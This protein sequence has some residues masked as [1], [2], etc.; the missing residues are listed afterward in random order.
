MEMFPGIRS[1]LFGQSYNLRERFP[2]GGVLGEQN[3]DKFFLVSLLALLI[4]AHGVA[5]SM[6]CDSIG[7]LEELKSLESFDIEE[8]TEVEELSDI[9]SWRSEHGGK[10]L[11]NIDSFGAAGDGESDDTEALQK[12]WGVAC[13]TPKSVL[14]IPQGRRYLVNATKFKRPCADKL[15]IQIDW[16]LVAPDEPKNWDPKLPRVWLDFSKLDKAVF[17]GSGVLMARENNFHP[18]KH[19]RKFI[20]EK[21]VYESGSWIRNYVPK[22]AAEIFWTMHPKFFVYFVFAL[23]LSFFCDL[24]SDLGVTTTNDPS[25]SPP[26]PGICSWVKSKKV[27]TQENFYHHKMSKHQSP[28]VSDSEEQVTLKDISKQLR[29]L[30]QWRIDTERKMDYA[31]QDRERK[32]T[33]IQDELRIMRD[34]Q[35]RMRGSR[36]GD[37]HH[38]TMMGTIL[39]HRRE[40]QEPPPPREV[41]INLPHFHGKDDVEAFLDWETKVEQLFACHQVSE[42]RKVPLATLSF[43]GYAMYWWTAIV[44]ERRR[45][46]NPPIRYWNDLITALRMRHIPSYY[47]R[48]LMDKL[49]R[50]QQN[51]MSVEQYRQKM[52]LYMIRAR[53]EETNEFTMARF[54]SGLNY[55]I[56]DK[57]ELL[58]Y[59]DLDSLVQM[60]IKVEQQNLRKSSH[61]RAQVQPFERRSFKEK[62]S[63]KPLAKIVEKPKQESSSHPRTS[64]IKCFKCLG[65]GHVAAQCPTKRN[66]ILRGK[67]IYS[68]ESDT[69]TSESEGETDKEEEVYADDG[70]LLM[71]RRVLSS[72][73]SLEHLSQRENIF[74]T[75][76]KIQENHCSLIVDSGSCCNCCSTRLVEKLKLDVVPHPKPYKL[77]WLNEDGDITVKNQVKLAF[78]IGNFK[79][80][81]FCDVVPMEAC[82]VLLGRPWQ[83]DHN[84]IH[85]GLTNTITVPKK[86][87]KFVLHPLTPAQV[88]QD[89]VQMKSTRDQEK[90]QK[91]KKG[92]KQK[93]EGCESSVPSKVTQHE[94][95]LNKKTLMNTLQVEQPSYLLLCQGTLTCT[96]SDSKTSTLSLPI[97]KLLK[98]FDDLFPKEIPIGLP[99]IRGIEHQID[100]IPGTTLPNRPA[101]RT[102]PQETKEIESQVQ[103]L[104]DKGLKDGKW[105]MCCDCRAINNITIKYRHP[106]PRLDDMLDELHGAQ[107]FSKIDLKSGY[108]QIRIKG[109]EW[110]TAFKTKFGLY[111]WLVMPFGLTNAPSTFM[112]LMN[113][114][115]R[116]CIGKFVVVY[117]DDIL[118]YSQDLHNHGKQLRIV[119]TILRTNKL[120]ANLDKCTF[121]V[122]SVIFLGFVVNKKGVHVDPEKIKAIQD[123]P[124]PKNVGEVRSFHGLASFYRR[125]VPN[126][127]SLASPLNELVKKDVTFIWGDKQQKAFELLK[128]KLTQAPILVLPNF[129]KTFELEC[130]DSGHGIGAVLLQGGHPIAYFSEKLHGASC[131]YPT[132]DKELYA[133]VWALQT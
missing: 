44:E 96:S 20:A 87:K 122:D 62:E 104:L 102:N 128:E 57:V 70:Q 68:S 19:Q 72:Q 53:I 123:W 37:S 50:L 39:R 34:E 12:A 31:Q 119:L 23:P 59:I 74:H 131:N 106:I 21:Q 124:P 94:V 58:P 107:I 120:F 69:P 95:L 117:F 79:D 22:T 111:E 41:N 46:Q 90:E 109:D 65:R 40:T 1:C 98:E 93:K 10:V 8:E 55:E 112:R 4:A 105:R 64:E 129:S 7:M 6:T 25:G 101:Y 118:V 78:S 16:T 126:F 80:E 121:C 51:S 18:R 36:S 130:D 81:V 88:A 66:I 103:E 60:C 35:G 56:R 76:C 89:Q 127:S 17:Q 63:F 24:I 27:V 61:K 13:S 52:E 132:Y 29:E 84:T 100:F 54:L 116:D 67:D 114:V 14:L 110:K 82:H 91:R 86:D 99:P 73:P 32:I 43:Q 133:L 77:H 113:N 5:G 2:L 125:F 85:H 71:V 42:E 47:H 30:T 3:M 9:P 97:Q 15:I 92:F 26:L 48:E 28:R 11:V 38:E 108:H 33:I 49:Q 75:R 45:H 83:F 115:L